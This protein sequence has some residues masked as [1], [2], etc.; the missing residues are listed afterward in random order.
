MKKIS[1]LQSLTS[2]SCLEDKHI[3][4]IAQAGYKQ[5]TNWSF[6]HMFS[7]CGVICAFVVCDTC[8]S[9]CSPARPFVFHYTIELHTCTSNVLI[10]MGTSVWYYIGSITCSLSGWWQKSTVIHTTES[11]TYRHIYWNRTQ[12]IHAH[13]CKRLKQSIAH[14]HLLVQEGI[15]RRNKQKSALIVWIQFQM[16]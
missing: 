10:L 4:E 15:P 1:T 3:S 13:K 5:M 16:I 8:I 12:K 11:I 2:S 7:V 14:V 9:S 6:L